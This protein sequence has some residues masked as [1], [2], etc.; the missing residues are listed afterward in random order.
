MPLDLGVSDLLC[1][2]DEV[3]KLVRSRMEEEMEKVVSP[4]KLQAVRVH[5]LP[6][7]F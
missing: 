6:S 3:R 5:H 7:Q 2:V 4:D 1:G